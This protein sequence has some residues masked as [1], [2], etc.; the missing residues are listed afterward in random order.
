MSFLSNLGSQFSSASG[1]DN[2]GHTLS[3][4]FSDKP[5]STPSGPDPL[6]TL[7]STMSGVGNWL[8]NSFGTPNLSDH[9]QDGWMSKFI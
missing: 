8:G 7:G 4:M 2:V 3:G 1:L 6:S 5:A 9:F